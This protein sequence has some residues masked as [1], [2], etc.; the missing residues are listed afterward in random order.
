MIGGDRI[1]V[2][3]DLA[4]RGPANSTINHERHISLFEGLGQMLAGGRLQNFPHDDNA[5]RLLQDEPLDHVPRD[6][7]GVNVQDIVARA[8]DGIDRA[9]VDEIAVPGAMHFAAL[10]MFRRVHNGG[11]GA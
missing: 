6:P 2:V 1:V 4:F 7:R 10:E 11:A 8:T 9:R 3:H 5:A